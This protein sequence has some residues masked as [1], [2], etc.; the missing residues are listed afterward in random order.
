MPNITLTTIFITN[1]VIKR[2][3]DDTTWALRDE[4]I[5]TWLSD[6][7]NGE[8]LCTVK[9][10]DMWLANDYLDDGA[11]KVFDRVPTNRGITTEQHVQ[12]M[13]QAEWCPDEN[14]YMPVDDDFEEH[15]IQQTEGY[16]ETPQDM[17]T[18]LQLEFVNR[19]YAANL[20][21]NGETG[22]NTEY[23][24]HLIDVCSEAI[25]DDFNNWA[26]FECEE[27][28]HC[29]GVDTSYLTDKEVEN[30]YL[31][32]GVTQEEFLDKYC[33]SLAPM[34]KTMIEYKELFDDTTMSIIKEGLTEFMPPN[35]KMLFKWHMLEGSEWLDEDTTRTP[36]GILVERVYGNETIT[37]VQEKIMTEE[38]LLDAQNKL[39][40][41]L[42]AGV[43]EHT[44]ELQAEFDRIDNLLNNL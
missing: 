1:N 9:P 10:Q 41:D 13:Q 43:V 5:V 38:E 27:D 28:S 29:K 26:A 11:I 14:V 34:E 44:P 20:T 24:Q 8:I 6:R 25:R 33:S 37:L 32:F 12:V 31:G 40:Q 39:I 4:L 36:T 19:C 21:R 2:Q 22:A 42:D 17:S 30:L 7:A 15:L 35:G 16:Y 18:E 23:R 3:L